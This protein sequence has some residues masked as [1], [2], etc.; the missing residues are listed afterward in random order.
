MKRTARGAP[1]WSI[2]EL[3][4]VAPD[5]AARL[6]RS[7]STAP[8]AAQGRPWSAA[9]P[10]QVIWTDGQV[11]TLPSKTEARVA[12]RLLEEARVAKARLYR[13]VRVPLLSIAPR[14]G[15][16]PLVLTV[17][18]ALVYPDGRKRYIDAKTRRTSPEWARG[19]A[20]A[21]AWLQQKIEEAAR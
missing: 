9:K 18:F 12:L 14:R 16:A 7:P 19:R 15:G 10:T 11:V 2:D 13:Q 21:E 5:V 3:R 8:P 17:D 1:H 6:E 4:R 20:A